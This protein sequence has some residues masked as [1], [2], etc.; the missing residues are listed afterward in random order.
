MA[1][2]EKSEHS[3]TDAEMDAI[4]ERAARRAL[5]IV[6]AEVGQNIVKRLFWIVGIVAIGILY[7]LAGRH[8]LSFS[9]MKE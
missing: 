6:Y 8:A 1:E 7:F 5:N 9:P 4:A 3:L 2:T